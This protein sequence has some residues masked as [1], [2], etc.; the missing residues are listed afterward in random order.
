[1]EEL[2]RLV[3][4]LHSR[5]IREKVL[6]KQ[7][8]KH[9][10]FMSQLCADSKDGQYMVSGFG[11]YTD[12]DDY[13]AVIVLCVSAGMD[14]AELEQQEV[15]EET[16]ESWCVEEQAMEVDIG[17]LQQVESLERKVISASLQVKVQDL[18]KHHTRI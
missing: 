8:Q 3:D 18:V 11:F 7:L 13:E 12:C 15:S 10:E 14:V 17:L 6:Q 2:Q 4:A 5:G 9:M 1:M 16:V